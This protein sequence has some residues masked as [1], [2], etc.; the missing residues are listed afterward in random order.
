MVFI[1]LD[2]FVCIYS[3]LSSSILKVPYLL[4]EYPM[5]LLAPAYHPRIK[6]EKTQINNLFESIQDEDT[7]YSIVL[8]NITAEETCSKHLHCIFFMCFFYI[9]YI[10]NPKYPK[11]LETCCKASCNFIKK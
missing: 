7:L 5:A 4:H 1:K 9:N 3:R 11:K 8:E 2:Q 10:F 6:C